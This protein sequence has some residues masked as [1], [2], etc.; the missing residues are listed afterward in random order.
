MSINFESAFSVLD[1][2]EKAIVAQVK[3]EIS[4]TVHERLSREFSELIQEETN[5]ALENMIIN[6]A[7]EKDSLRMADNV[8]ILVEWIKCREE[9]R[10]LRTTTVI[11]QDDLP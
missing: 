9:K 11:V 5:R 3:E 10:R 2:A 4:R 1:V 8:R 7:H 6:L